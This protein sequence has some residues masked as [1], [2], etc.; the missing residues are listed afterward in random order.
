[1]DMDNWH[2]P[3]RPGAG[4]MPPYLAGRGQETK[5]FI[6]LLSQEVV[7]KNVV[8]TG[9]R[10]VGKTVLLETLKPE[11]QKRGWLW[12]GTDFSEAASSTEEVLATRILTDLGVL[13]GSLLAS[14]DRV[15]SVGFTKA[16]KEVKKPIGYQALR[17][18]YETTPGLVSDKLKRVVTDMWAAIS[19]NVEDVRGIIFAYDEA[20][21]MSDHAERNQYPLALLLDVFQSLQRTGVKAML[22]LSG[23][24][25]LFP[26]LVESRTFAER[27]FSII[28]LDSLSDE[29]A[30]EAVQRPLESHP[31]LLRFNEPFVRQI[32]E[33][34]KGYPYFVQFICRETFDLALAHLRANQS[35]ESLDVPVQG[36]LRKLD[37]D[38]FAGRW[39]KATDRQRDLMR[40]IANLPNCEDEFTVSEIVSGSRDSER[41]F[42]SSHV[43]Q[44]LLA[45][46]KQGLVYKNRHG[47][48]CFAVPLMGDFIRRLDR[49][50]AATAGDQHELF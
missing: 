37:E 19:A 17:E 44:M 39:A 45:L 15:E 49:E 20:Q 47:K 4:H 23:L 11:A 8:L 35:L 34:S 13:T 9:L 50:S 30:G 12:A 29:E 6:A 28:T 46:I 36:I 38:F 41:P 18:I 31:S 42:S 2:N 21:N 7:L 48:Y 32:V 33:Q 40:V 16:Q 25:T 3:Y 24:P 22:V 27:M 43:N 1:M 5:Q 14:V 10:G 26:K